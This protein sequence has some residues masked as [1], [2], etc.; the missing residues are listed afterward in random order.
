MT[1]CI[2]ESSF[3]SQGL[4]LEM[5]AWW[6][7]P[8][9]LM[10]TPCDPCK[11]YRVGAEKWGGQSRKTIPELLISCKPSNKTCCRKPKGLVQVSLTFLS[12]VTWR[13]SSGVA[14]RRG[15]GMKAWM[16]YQTD[17]LSLMCLHCLEFKAAGRQ[18][19]SKPILS[20][21]YFRVPLNIKMFW[22]IHIYTC[23][24]SKCNNA[25]RALGTQTVLQLKYIRWNYDS[26]S[27]G[28]YLLP[29]YNKQ[30]L[31][32]SLKTEQTVLART[33]ETRSPRSDGK[34]FHRKY[35]YWD[36]GGDHWVARNS[37]AKPGRWGMQ[38]RTIIMPR[39]QV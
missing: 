7:F 16:N 35:H 19:K 5:K 10:R 1:M 36:P 27:T 4:Q 22:E 8:H 23:L 29:A 2:L 6:Q 9:H 25:H 39:S 31:Y 33:Y 12:A 30:C 13:Y 18:F 14:R 24:F 21:A 37:S 3:Q 34:G 20:P 32:H 26:M 11:C 17:D 15:A 28:L 38:R